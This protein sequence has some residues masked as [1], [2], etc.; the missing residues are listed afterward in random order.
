MEEVN[1]GFLTIKV[2]VGFATLFFIIIITGRTS[3]SQLTPFHLVFVLVLGDF[4]GNT[5][6][7]DKVRTF[8][9]LYA[10][11]LWTLLMLVIEFMTLKNKSIRSLLLGDPNII[12][13]DGVMDRK[14]LKKNKLDVNQVLSILRQNNVFSVREV[15]YGILEA[16]GEIS[17]LLKSKYQNP[18]K[19]DLNLPESQVDLPTS[20]IIDGE[21]LWDNLHELGFDQQWLDNQLTTNG[22]DNVKR[23]LYA[24]WRE[25]EGI[26]VSPK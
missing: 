5:I 17:L 15:K 19:Q 22:Y 6:Y 3:I 9:F 25:S 26:H 11:G 10:I 21:I 1:I 16:N 14:L 20:L 7:E 23:I 12:I 18:D 24:D 4:L 13:R 8:H 2:I